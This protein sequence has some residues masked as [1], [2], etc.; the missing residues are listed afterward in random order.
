MRVE[1]GVTA[2]N[3]VKGMVMGENVPAWRSTMR[4]QGLARIEPFRPSGKMLPLFLL[5]IPRCGAGSVATFLEGIYGPSGI[6]RD[7]GAR[8]D[9]I[10]AGRLPATTADCV[11]GAVPLVRWLHFGGAA[12][13]ARATVLR[14][15]WARLVSQINHLAAIGPEGAGPGGTTRRALAEEVAR[16]DFT[17]RIGLER[18]SNRLRLID[19]GFDNVQV[20]MLITGTMS[21]MVKQITARDVD[22]ALRELERFAVVGFCEEQLDMQRVLVRLTGSKVATGAVFEGAGRG[23]VLSVR[24]NLA[25]EALIGLYDQDLELYTR[26]RNLFVARQR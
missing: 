18:F 21:A 19:G 14:N 13:Y 16:T 23:L 4:P 25:R 9:D 6:V 8:V 20:R 2:D 3:A 26:A 10:F 24:N 1:S 15:P 17:S 7:A 22:V 5:Q 11:V 12:V